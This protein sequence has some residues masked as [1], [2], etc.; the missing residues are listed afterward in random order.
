M[1]VCSHMSPGAY[2]GQRCQISG[3]GVEGDCEPLGMGAGN[4]TQVRWKSRTFCDLNH[5]AIILTPE[6][7]F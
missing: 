1:Y 6:N 4:Q 5:R 7:N 3:T 2:R